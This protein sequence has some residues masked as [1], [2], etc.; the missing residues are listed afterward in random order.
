[1]MMTTR[2]RHSP[3]HVVR[4]LASEDR[5]LGEART[6]R[7]FAASWGGGADVLPLA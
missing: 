7:T 1:M 6:L 3:E 4:K 5:M 2:K